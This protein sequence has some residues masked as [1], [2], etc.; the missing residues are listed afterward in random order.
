[1]QLDTTKLSSEVKFEA[2]AP[3]GNTA[4]PAE[5]HGAVMLFPHIYGPIT[6]ESVV[7]VLPVHRAED[8]AFVRI[9]A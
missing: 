1:L 9:G 4:P 3:V 6:T 8:G 7:A 5:G 2:P